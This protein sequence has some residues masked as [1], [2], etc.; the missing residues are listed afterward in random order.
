MAAVFRRDGQRGQL[1]TGHDAPHA[2][3]W[4]DT[5]K[6][7]RRGRALPPMQLTRWTEERERSEPWADGAAP[8]GEQLRWQAF[9][10]P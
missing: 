2:H 8:H 9:Q 10:M 5:P 6:N 3:V 4:Q 7:S 1:Q